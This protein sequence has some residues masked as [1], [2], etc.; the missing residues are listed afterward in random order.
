M[1]D[2]GN[3]KSSASMILLGL[4]P[5]ETSCKDI[6]SIDLD[7]GGRYSRTFTIS[8]TETFPPL[9]CD[10]LKPKW[11]ISLG[12]LSSNMRSGTRFLACGSLFS[13]TRN[14]KFRCGGISRL[15]QLGA[16][17]KRVRLTSYGWRDVSCSKMHPRSLATVFHI[18]ALRTKKHTPFS[19][20]TPQFPKTARQ[21]LESSYSEE[22]KTH[23]FL[24][25]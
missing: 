2:S 21:P 11:K 4:P 3:H 10:F 20:N 12:T 15:Q 18:T 17:I 25:K 22:K 8:L 1:A 7:D 23:P 9:R 16:Y 6:R 14:P 13:A 24:Q 19:K 5:S